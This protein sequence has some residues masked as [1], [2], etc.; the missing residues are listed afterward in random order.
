[1]LF[2]E[3]ADETVTLSVESIDGGDRIV[4]SVRTAEG[5][6]VRGE[7]VPNGVIVSHLVDPADRTQGIRIALFD[8]DS[9][10]VRN[11]GSHLR[12]T[13]RWFPWQAGVSMGFFWHC[14]EPAVARLFIDQTGALVR[15]DPETG[16]MV[17]VVGGRK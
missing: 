16:D 11:I 1:V 2:T 9:G 15:W 3:S 7:A 5:S 12:S 4:H 8:V 13:V 6:R 10:E 14:Y 17:H